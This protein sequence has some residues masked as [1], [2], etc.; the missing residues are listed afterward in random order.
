[1]G[2]DVVSP[3]AV[4]VVEVVARSQLPRFEVFRFLPANYADQS[5]TGP[6]D[7]EVTTVCEQEP[8]QGLP[9]RNQKG[10]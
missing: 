5:A 9:S 4:A 3:V 2:H 7:P 8:P 6:R 10:K 1:M